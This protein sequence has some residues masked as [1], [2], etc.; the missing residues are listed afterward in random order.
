HY[1]VDIPPRSGPPPD[2]GLTEEQVL[3]LIGRVKTLP[4]VTITPILRPFEEPS[5]GLDAL[6]CELWFHLDEDLFTYEAAVRELPFQILA[7]I[8]DDLLELR[9]ET[10]QIKRN[11]FRVF[12]GSPD[13]GFVRG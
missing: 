4:F 9:H 12:I 10:Q 3:E 13:N 5:N 2:G 7:E 1:I 11:V 8:D 6:T